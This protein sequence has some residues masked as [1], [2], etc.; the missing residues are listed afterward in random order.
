MLT[1]TI[2]RRPWVRQAR[3]LRVIDGDSLS[4]ELDLGFNMRYVGSIRLDGIDTPELRG[5]APEEIARGQDAKRYVVTWLIDAARDASEAW[6]LEI[7][8]NRVDKYG[9]WLAYVWRK[10]DG[11]CLNTDLIESGRARE[12]H[13]GSRN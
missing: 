7:E 6:P 10:S 3:A 12:Y 5:R 13:G 1:P 2:A 4:I 9:R 11:R 8:T